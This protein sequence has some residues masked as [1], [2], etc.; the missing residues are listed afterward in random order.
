MCF[1][2]IARGNLDQNKAVGI[3]TGKTMTLPVK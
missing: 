2:D 3:K 1:Y